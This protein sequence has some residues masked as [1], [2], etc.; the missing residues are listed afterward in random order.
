MTKWII[1]SSRQQLELFA[2]VLGTQPKGR[3]VYPDKMLWFEKHFPTSFLISFS[4]EVIHQNGTTKALDNFVQRKLPR[5]ETLFNPSLLRVQKLKSEFS[6]VR[7]QTQG[8]GSKPNANAYSRE[9]AHEDKKR[10]KDVVML[11][12]ANTEELE[13]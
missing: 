11:R 3:S 5:L 9:C 6:P 2:S 4:T 8:T 1:R 7:H 13:C 12:H 10:E